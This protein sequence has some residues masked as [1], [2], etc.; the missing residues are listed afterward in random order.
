MSRRR[1]GFTL[2]ELL[3]ALLILSLLATM[4]WRGLDAVLDTREHVLAETRKWQAVSAFVSRFE[5][6]LAMASPRPVRSGGGDSPAWVG[7]GPGG[8]A[9]RLELSR[10]A[11]PQGVDS[12]R[13]IAYQL[14]DSRQIELWLWSGLD[15]TPGERPARYPVLEDVQT[16]ELDYLDQNLTWVPTWPASP[17][18]P[19]M[20]RAVRLQLVLGSGERILRLFAVDA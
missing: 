18:S 19:T 20:P 1:G 8:A 2:I 17:D 9:P 7:R 15:A 3:V 4:S 13:R 6:D 10:F 11:S 16:L 14:N 12:P 5:R